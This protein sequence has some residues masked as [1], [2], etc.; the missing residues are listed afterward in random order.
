MSATLRSWRALAVCVVA[1]GSAGCGDMARQ[2]QS[3]VQLTILSLEGASGAEPD[4]FGAVV[5]SDVVTNV[6]RLV[7]GE[8]VT[9]STIFGDS[10]VAQFGL[11][12]KDPG[13]PLAPSAPSA[14]NAVTITRYRVVYKRADEPYR[15]SRRNLG[16]MMR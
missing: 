6:Q 1:F 7:D 13:D 12:M 4:E 10:G 5:H 14:L 16:L 9:V 3:P 2:S 15:H 11:V 8:Q